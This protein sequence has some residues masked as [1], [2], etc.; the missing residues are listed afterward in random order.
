MASLLSV[1]EALP[2]RLVLKKNID[3]GN[4]IKT[5]CFLSRNLTGSYRRYS[6]RKLNDCI[7]SFLLKK[8]Y[9]FLLDK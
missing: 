3:P 6:G 1:L 4:W 2:P 8:Q 5:F 9:K 7:I